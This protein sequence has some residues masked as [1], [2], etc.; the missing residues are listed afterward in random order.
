MAGNPPEY[1]L[2]HD[3]ARPFVTRDSINRVVEKLEG[4]AKAVVPV[5]PIA[6]TIKEVAAGK[7]VRTLPRDRLARAQTPQGF[8]FSVI[9][10]A[11]CNAK[12]QDFT[13][14]AA[15]A[16]EAGIEVETVEGDLRNIK[17]TRPEDIKTETETCVGMGF[18]AHRFQGAETGRRTPENFVRLC[19]VNIPHHRS[20]DG[21]S[22]AD[23]GLHAL[24]DALL[25]AIGKGD[26]GRHF[27][28]SDPRWK[29]ADSARFVEHAR[30]LLEEKRGWVSNVD[31]TII[32]EMPKISMHR[33]AMQA[34]IAELLG[35]APGR[36]NVKATTTE[37]LGF[38]GRGEGIAVQAAV[39]VVLS[40]QA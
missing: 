2:I 35:M 26:I 11:H 39:A 5:I 21:H 22:D 9:F 1:V 36:V 15:V 6:D 3:A 34:R 18:D 33:D 17:V 27:P 29:G 19:G 23:V 24:V 4:G 13:D 7:A 28:P 12:E 30:K 20:L 31:I 8:R 38:T 16:E 14:D 32:C 25:G 40:Y 10:E 37:G